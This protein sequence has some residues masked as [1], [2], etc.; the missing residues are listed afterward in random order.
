[1]SNRPE[2]KFVFWI[3]IAIVFLVGAGVGA[4]LTSSPPS[5]AKVSIKVEEPS[6]ESSKL[7]SFTYATVKRNSVHGYSFPVA[8][9]E[10][11]GH[12]FVISGGIV[13]HPSCPCLKK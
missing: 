11:D 3:I 4:S 2:L 7:I 12:W 6:E 9:V 13:H 1:M 5:S 10:H 8:T